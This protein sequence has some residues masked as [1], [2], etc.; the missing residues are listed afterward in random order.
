MQEN[1]HESLIELCG[2]CFD[3]N[4]LMMEGISTCKTFHRPTHQNAILN[5]IPC[6]GHYAKIAPLSLTL[7]QRNDGSKLNLHSFSSGNS[8]VCAVDQEKNSPTQNEKWEVE[9]QWRF[10]QSIALKFSADTKN[11]PPLTPF[12]GQNHLKFQYNAQVLPLFPSHRN[13]FISAPQSDRILPSSV[14][15]HFFPLHRTDQIKYRARGIKG[16]T[17]CGT[18]KTWDTNECKYTINCDGKRRD[19]PW[20]LW[21]LL[22]EISLKGESLNALLFKK[23]SLKRLTR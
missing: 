5:L 15:K 19:H 18:K 2:H 21:Q 3:A 20:Q 9:S 22:R 16:S 11:S 17:L 13:Y 1:H 23:T 12:A 14:A 4:W 8:L 6:H 10:C 7:A